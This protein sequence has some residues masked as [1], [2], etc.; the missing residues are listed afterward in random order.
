MDDRGR[1]ALAGGNLAGRLVAGAV[2]DR[3]GRVPALGGAL[4]LVGGSLL[5]LVILGPVGQLAAYLGVGTGYGALS[6]LV[7][8][9]I[10]DLVGR[11]RFA[12]VYGRVFTAWG[13]AGL[14]GPLAGGWL[15]DRGSGV[16]TAVGVVSLLLI[17]AAA[18]TLA[19]ARVA[20]TS[21]SR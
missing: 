6:A 15:L 14:A 16:P 11:R 10:A 7:P 17:P 19:L 12:S 8:A 2:S 18:A 13:S 5:G 1:L 9:A 21:Q 3:V 4:L 20:R